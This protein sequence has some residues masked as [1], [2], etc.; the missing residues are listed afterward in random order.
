MCINTG[1]M[2]VTSLICLRIFEL[3]PVMLN[4]RMYVLSSLSLSV[5]DIIS[6]FAIHSLY[7]TSQQ[8]W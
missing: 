3:L 4:L 5:I 2:Y 8:F 6:Y 1:R 7:V